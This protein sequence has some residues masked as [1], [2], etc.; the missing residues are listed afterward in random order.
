MRWR[1]LST[2]ALASLGISSQIVLGIF[3]I[4]WE[5]ITECLY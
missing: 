4:G 1:Q 3:L 5:T 2:C